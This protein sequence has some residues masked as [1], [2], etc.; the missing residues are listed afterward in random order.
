MI[1]IEEQF[2]SIENLDT[3]DTYYLVIS[4]DIRVYSDYERTELVLVAPREDKYY[5]GE[6]IWGVR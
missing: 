5:I 1:K 6:Q 2:K 3:G 4:D